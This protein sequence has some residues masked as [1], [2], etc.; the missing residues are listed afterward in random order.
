M[1]DNK[2]TFLDELAESLVARMVF[3]VGERPTRGVGVSYFDGGLRYEWCAS[4]LLEGQTEALR[5]SVDVLK[6]LFPLSRAE[7]EALASRI[8]VRIEERLM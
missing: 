4:V 5:S 2:E 7:G 6:Y 1:P 3:R 8:R